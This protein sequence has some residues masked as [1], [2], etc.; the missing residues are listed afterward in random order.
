MGNYDDTIAIPVQGQP[1][2]ASTYGIPMRNA[3]IAL[4]GRI[5]AFDG[6]TGVSIAK[7]TASLVLAT[8][9]ETIALTIPA[10][11]FRAGMA[12][13]ANIRSGLSSAAAGTLVNLRL[14]KGNTLSLSGTTATNVDYGEYFRFEGKGGSVMSALGSIYLLRTADTDLTTDFCLTGQSSVA[15]ANAITLYAN[16]TSP[17]YL[18]IEPVGFASLY[19]GMGI[20]V[21]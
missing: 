1:I 21:T 17:R 15:A 3:V 8:L 16:A 19:T 7:S 5:S 4:D 11:T 13:R 9:N 18:V 2:S 6:S 14:R 12:Y 10:F 20:A